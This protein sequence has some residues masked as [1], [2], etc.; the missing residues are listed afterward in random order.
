MT[1]ILKSAPQPGLL[2]QH[3]GE[4]A[5]AS[6][7]TV[8]AAATAAS[9]LAACGGGGGSDSAPGPG[10]AAAPPP[11]DTTAPLPAPEPAPAPSPQAAPAPVQAPEPLTPPPPGPFSDAEASRFLAQAGFAASTADI[12]AVKLAGYASWLDQQF[13]ATSLM[14][15]YDWMTAQ[16]YGGVADI[17]DFNG[18]DGA[19]WRQWLSAP[20]QLRQ[21]M[22]LALSEI[23]VVSMVGLELPFRGMAMCDYVDMLSSRAFGNFRDLLDGVAK[24]CVMGVYLS[25]LG[26]KKANAT[27]GSSPDENFPRE[28]MQLMTIGLVQLN[29]DGTPVLDSSGVPVP[30]YALSDVVNLAAVFTGWTYDTPSMTDPAYVR[31]PMINVASNFSTGDKKVLDVDIPASAD[32]PAAMKIALDT[33]VAHPN[34]GPFIG[35]QLI[36]R[37]V[38]SSPSAAYVKRVASAFNDNGSGQRG[39]MKAVIRAVLY[40]TEARTLSS[41]NGAGKLREPMLRF[42]QWGRT[43]GMATPTGAWAMG[44]ASNASTRLGQS[45]LHSP[46][47][48]NFFRPGYVPPNSTMATQGITAPEFQLCNEVTVGGYL[49]FMQAV[50]VSGSGDVKPNYSAQIAL[51]TDAV[52]LVTSISMLMAADGLSAATLATISTAVGK[53]TSASDSGKLARVQAAILLVMASPEYLIQK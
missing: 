47:V 31:L 44:D 49:N 35:R 10:V 9:L 33:L 24:H 7:L 52:A 25:M 21:R 27:P 15:N 53:I 40:D 50:I 29:L 16:G 28:V 46:S 4:E 5:G 38:C 32:G 11:A 8:S 6:L 23:F 20:D 22:T 13:A 17:I 45:P 37:L 1:S 3:E 51:A 26:S 43:F 2:A 36:Q 48:F 42:I 18:T 30:T 14:S 41:A 12:A 19:L 39:D 34:V